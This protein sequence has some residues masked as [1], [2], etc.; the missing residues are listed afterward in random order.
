MILTIYKGKHYSKPRRWFRLWCCRKHWR[1]VFKMD[2]NNWYPRHEVDKTGISKMW[3]IGMPIHAERPFGKIPLIK[4]LINSIIIGW[5]PDFDQPGTINIHIITDRN[6][7]EERPFFCKIQTGQYYEGSLF[8]YK[9][10]AMLKI[11][12]HYRSFP[13]KS[14]MRF[15]YHISYFFGGR[16]CA[17]WKMKLDWEESK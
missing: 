9:K 7:V 15:G 6:G 5:Q 8:L 10:T 2:H 13:I 17:P 14:R 4:K 16:S 3:G 1:F 12:S 11:G